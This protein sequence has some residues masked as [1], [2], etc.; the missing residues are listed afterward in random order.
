MCMQC[1]AQ[2]APAVG[3]AL[4]MLNRRNLRTWVSRATRPA[5][6]ALPRDATSTA[7]GGGQVA[8]DAGLVEAQA[9]VDAAGGSG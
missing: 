8:S 3:V 5:G 9:G 4:A 2:S 6:P 1:V 7:G